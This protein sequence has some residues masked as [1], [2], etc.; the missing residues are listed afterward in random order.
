MVTWF[1]RES[2]TG[3]DREILQSERAFQ[4]IKIGPFVARQK[5]N[6]KISITRRIDPSFIASVYDAKKSPE[7]P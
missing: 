5:I 6:T 1:Y 4:V 2:E 7:S 3:Q